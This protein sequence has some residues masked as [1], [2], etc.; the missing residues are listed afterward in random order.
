MTDLPL[1]MKLWLVDNP[2]DKSENLSV[3]SLI[4]PIKMLILSKRV[5]SVNGE[6]DLY[7]QISSSIG[8]AIHSSIEN[9]W[10]SDRLESNLELLG[11]DKKT[12]SAIRINP[13]SKEEGIIPVYIEK[14]TDKVINGNTITGKFDFVFNGILE[15]F[16]STSVITYI[17]QSN[18]DKFILQGSIY[19]WLNPDIITEDYMLI[20]YIFTDFSVAESIRNEEYPKTRCLSQKYPLISL[21]MTESYIRSKL[22]QLEELDNAEEKDIPAC[23]KDEIWQQDSVW[24]YYKNKAE[25]SR[26]TKNFS[27]SYDAYD[28]YYKDGSIGIVLEVKSQPKLCPR[29]EANSICQQYQSILSNG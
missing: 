10:K 5:N 3:T 29:C 4:K 23:T 20:N 17:N 19:R 27:N 16:K 12:I 1:S 28:R 13:E 22:R 8:N 26:S 15:D 9:C 18:K 21:A 6:I 2:Y 7:K 24:K 14:R 25:L 11:L